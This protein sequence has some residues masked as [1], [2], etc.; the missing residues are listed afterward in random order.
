MKFPPFDLKSEAEQEVYRLIDE[1]LRKLPKAKDGSI[2]S[3][4]LGF[5]DNEIDALRHTFVS[6]AYTQAYGSST[7]EILGRLYE[8]FPGLGTSRMIPAFWTV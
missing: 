1:K 3:S 8:Y 5:Q 6:G 7:A 4:A 2:D